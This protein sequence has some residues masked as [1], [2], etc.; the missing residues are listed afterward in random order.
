PHRVLPTRRERAWPVELVGVF[1]V[2]Y[3]QTELPGAR[4]RQDQ[5]DVLVEDAALEPLGIGSAES[6]PAHRLRD[7]C[8]ANHLE[9]ADADREVRVGPGRTH[10]DLPS[11]N[12]LLRLAIASRTLRGR[13]SVPVASM[14]S[15]AVSR[16][17]ADRVT[18]HPAGTSAKLGHSEYWSSSL[19]STSKVPS[20]S[21]KGLL[22]MVILS[23]SQL[24]VAAKV[25]R[26]G[27]ASAPTHSA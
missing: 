26:G 14:C 18:R 21:S 7:P 4:V 6:E 11:V 12:A 16:S 22:L 5:L 24:S 20:S 1:T 15:S 17:V 23:F 2:G 13:R 19:T 27:R 8:R 10:Q 9:L 25:A 3:R